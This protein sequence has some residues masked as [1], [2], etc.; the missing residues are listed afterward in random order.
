MR[1]LRSPMTR[2]VDERGGGVGFRSDGGR[3]RSAGC[4]QPTRRLAATGG[5]GATLKLWWLGETRV[6][7][8]HDWHKR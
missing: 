5:R 7:A 3:G 1:Q 2:G 8:R 4:E 6:A